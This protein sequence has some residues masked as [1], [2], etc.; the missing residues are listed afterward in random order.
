MIPARLLRVFLMLCVATTATSALGQ[1]WFFTANPGA[2]DD[3]LNWDVGMVPNATSS[4]HVGDDLIGTATANITGDLSEPI[5]KDLRVG[6]GNT[7]GGGAVGTINHSAGTLSN[8]T[9]EWTFIGV[10]GPT[11]NPNTGTYNLSGTATY[12]NDSQLHV[13][14]GG[15]AEFSGNQGA[16]HVSGN[17][18]ANLSGVYVGSNNASTG[19]LTIADDAIVGINQ[20]AVG[21]FDG[22]TGTATISGNAIVNIDQAF[23]GKESGSNGVVTQTGGTV[24]V[25]NW[26]AIGESSGA[27]GTY[28]ISGG[29]LTQNSDFLSIGQ[30]SGASG[31]MNVSGTGSVTAANTSIGRGGTGV[32]GSE[33]MGLLTIDGPDASFSTDVLRV[34]RNDMNA[35]VDAIGTIEFTSTGGVTPIDV[36]TAVYLND[37]SIAGSANLLVNLDASSRSS[38]TDILL[39]SVGEGGMIDGTFAGLP[40][41]ALVPNSGNRTISYMG[42]D[43]NDIVLLGGGLLTCDFDGSGS[44]DIDEHRHVDHGGFDHERESHV[45]PQWRQ[46][47]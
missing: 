41:G 24:N 46:P 30:D 14:Y 5:I 31:T 16:F 13:G 3:F 27:T 8:G 25:T 18:T 29:S 32:P 15:S 17:A 20:L 10:D 36:A 4:V 37:G 21:Q 6:W 34:A 7:F 42:G 39:I 19:E 35:I 11:A 9:G 23:V 33:V 28:N 38:G 26:L 44:C 47:G 22:S 1:D 2:W 12:N 43:G 45:R 40:E